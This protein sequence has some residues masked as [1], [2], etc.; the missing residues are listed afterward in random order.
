MS[1]TD[2]STFWHDGLGDRS[3][4]VW[5]RGAPTTAIEPAF[6]TPALARNLLRKTD[7]AAPVPQRNRRRLAIPQGDVLGQGYAAD[8]DLLSDTH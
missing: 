6:W 5:H 3:L 1:I 7:S 8:W 4:A 2:P